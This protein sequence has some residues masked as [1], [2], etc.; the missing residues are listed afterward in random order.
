MALT[1][2][3]YSVISEHSSCGAQRIPTAHRGTECNKGHEL[4]NGNQ[5][6]ENMKLSERK[7]GRHS[8]IKP[9]FCAYIHMK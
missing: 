2:L 8:R 9:T 6:V 5:Y 1:T 4:N 3:I 7:C